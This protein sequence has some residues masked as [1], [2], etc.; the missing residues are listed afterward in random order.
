M[1]HP[2]PN[3]PSDTTAPPTSA[4]ARTPHQSA[5]LYT[6][7]LSSGGI[8]RAERLH[9]IDMSYT[10]YLDAD[11][12]WRVV[13]DFPEPAV[14]IIKHTNPC[15][16]AVHPDQPTAYRLAFEGDSVSAYGGIV[17]FNRP[18]TADTARAMRG[19]LFDI[20]VAP[21]YD[22]EALKTLRRRTRTRILKVAPESGP[23]T[24]L[25]LRPVTGGALIQTPDD[26]ARRPRRLAGRNRHRAHRRPTPRPRP[27]P[28]APASTSNPTP[29]S[30]PK[31]T[32]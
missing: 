12:A 2:G 28:G 24:R 31:T 21:G 25:D 23:G 13:S 14:A 27:S 17:G 20:I 9:G 18:V 32:T 15:G 6:S 7:A 22:E 1:I 10:N 3:S 8:V 30:S 5:T 19:V 29:S 4:T 26:I 16:L 11:A